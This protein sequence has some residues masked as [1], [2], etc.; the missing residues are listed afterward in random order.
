[1]LMRSRISSI[2]KLGAPCLSKTARTSAVTIALVPG[3]IR[4]LLAIRASYDFEIA[5]SPLKLIVSAVP[6]GWC[7]LA[8]CLQAG[9]PRLGVIGISKDD[10]N[11]R[12]LPHRQIFA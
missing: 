7:L 6:C 9:H 12:V 4:S 5:V 1:M 8:D 2:S 3:L 10:L 11:F